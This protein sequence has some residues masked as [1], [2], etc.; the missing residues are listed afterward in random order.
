MVD[1]TDVLDPAI[2]VTAGIATASKPFRDGKGHFMK[3]SR[4]GN[5]AKVRR[6]WDFLMTMAASGVTPQPLRYG[7]DFILMQDLGD[8]EPVPIEEHPLVASAAQVILD[9]LLAKGIRHNDLRP[10]NL[11]WYER[12]LYCIDF[13]RALWT[14]ESLS[15]YRE[16][17]DALLIR[18]SV[19]QI[20]AGKVWQ[21]K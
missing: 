1:P 10:Q 19:A 2:P 17:E 21:W 20:I 6:E 5:A 15:G 7:D 8:S 11:I 9:S 13:G 4:G 14:G 16:N 12:K 18:D 3:W